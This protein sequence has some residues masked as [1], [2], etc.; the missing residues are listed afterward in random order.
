[1]DTYIALLDEQVTLT[2]AM[3]FSAFKGPFA[4][5]IDLW[6][7]ALQN[8]SEVIEEW[9]KVQRSWMYLQP[10]FESPDINKQ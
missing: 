4:Q 1:V 3:T 9:L 10:I 2:Q 7:E 6:N 5:R 8:T